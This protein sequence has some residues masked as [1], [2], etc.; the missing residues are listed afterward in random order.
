[1]VNNIVVFGAS[2][3][4]GT[5]ALNYVKQ[6]YPYAN[7]YGF[8]QRDVENKVDGI[9][10]EK[11]K[12]TDELAIAEAA[13]KV[14]LNGNIDLVFV[15][16]GMLHDD[17]ITPEKSLKQLSFDNFEKILQTI[18]FV[19]AILAKY[20]LPKMTKNNKS[21]FAIL[22]A[23]VGSISDNRLGGWYA[24]RMSKAALNMFIKC[25]SIEMKRINKDAIIVGLHPGTVD[26]R[27]SEPFQKAVA[28]GHLFT[29]E[30]SVERLFGVLDNLNIEDSGKC[31][32][33]DGEEV[34]P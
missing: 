20:F 13:D 6:K 9:R 28:K 10:Y 34:L 18:T 12:Y 27:L 23:R 19:P 29:P 2:G 17:T 30:Y 32:A 16:V 14:A 3:T 5:A 25:A 22:S 11:I 21:I 7:I 26:S 24:Y 31:F 1:M 8:S 4:I 15:A 33:W